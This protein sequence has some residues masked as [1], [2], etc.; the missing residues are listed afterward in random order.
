MQDTE[1]LSLHDLFRSLAD[2]QTGR[3]SLLAIEAL[4]DE[5]KQWVVQESI[6]KKRPVLAAFVTLPSHAALRDANYSAGW[7]NEFFP[8]WI[9]PQHQSQFTKDVNVGSNL[10]S[11]AENRPIDRG[12]TSSSR[13]TEELTNHLGEKA[14]ELSQIPSWSNEANSP[15]GPL[16]DEAFYARYTSLLEDAEIKRTDQVEEPLPCLEILADNHFT[17]LGTMGNFSVIIGKPKSRKTFLLS[18]LVAALVKNDVVMDCVRGQL[19]TNK[20]AILYFDTEQIRG[21]V[22]RVLNRI[23]SLTGDVSP[24]SIRYFGLRRYATIDRLNAIQVAIEQTLNLGAIII[25]GIRDTVFDINDPKEATQRATD[26]L[27]WTEERDAHLITVIHENKGNASA[28]GHLGSELVNKAETVVSVTRDEADTRQS[29]VKAEFCRDKEFNPFAFIIDEQGLPQ[30]MNGIPN[31]VELKRSSK[32]IASNL[33][34]EQMENLIRR[35]YANEEQIGYSQLRTNLIE[36]SEY[37]GFALAK[38]K[39]ESLIRRMET[40]NYLVKTKTA[41]QQYPVYQINLEKLSV[42]A[43]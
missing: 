31:Q 33:T 42:Q 2:P 8:H 4:P 12:H 1:N 21:H 38:S 18:A 39:A 17:T 15:S 3:P 37:L 27:R 5:Q 35:A 36:A 28:R 29:I 9:Q 19:P 20:R 14:K 13:F 23:A 40:E 16:G 26:L 24:S 22:Q 25:D 34:R 6:R 11:V 7:T 32:V 30:R 10:R 43:S 41:K